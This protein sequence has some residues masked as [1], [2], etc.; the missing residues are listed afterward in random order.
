MQFDH[1]KIN[2]L[3]ALGKTSEEMDAIMSDEGHPDC[4]KVKVMTTILGGDSLSTLA[5]L[6]ALFS[7][8][9]LRGPITENFEK[10]FELV[11]DNDLEVLN[12]YMDEKAKEL[13]LDQ[14]DAIMKDMEV[15]D[16]KDK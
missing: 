10:L 13:G 14:V 11:S 3:E 12:M 1:T 2:I 9:P 15:A 16:A 7:K 4:L 6:I 8:E 5:V